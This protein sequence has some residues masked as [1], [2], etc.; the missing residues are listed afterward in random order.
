LCLPAVGRGEDKT[1]CPDFHQ[2]SSPWLESGEE[3]IKG[4]SKSKTLKASLTPIAN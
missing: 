3:E 2:G 4:T 1:A